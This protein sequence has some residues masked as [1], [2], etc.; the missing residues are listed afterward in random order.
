MIW[1][2]F[3]VYLFLVIWE[4]CSYIQSASINSNS[5]FIPLPLVPPNF[6]CSLFF[7][8]HG[9]HSAPLKY[10][11]ME[12]QLLNLGPHLWWEPIACV[13]PAI[14][15]QCPQ[16]GVGHHDHLL[17]PC[18]DLVWVDSVQVLAHPFNCWVHLCTNCPAVSWKHRFI[19]LIHP[20]APSLLRVK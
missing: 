16:P 17:A 15:C 5:S 6:K 4:F 2:L 20:S 10:I 12:R 14:S 3:A 7:P 1:K 11:L 18:G 19:L 13:F 8:T 9:F